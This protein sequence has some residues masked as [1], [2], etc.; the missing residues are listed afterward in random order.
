M[1][2]RVRERPRQSPATVLID[3][4]VLLD[5]LLD[6]APWAA[7]AARLLDA[8]TTGRLRGFVAVH[9]I[10][11]VHY[12]IEREHGRA[13]AATAISDLLDLLEVVPLDS[14]DLRRAL[15]LGLKDFE[16]AVHA[17]ACQKVGAQ[18]LVTRNERDYR[19]T[20]VTTR[21][22]AEVLAL[23]AITDR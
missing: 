19:D 15:A 16:D 3:T 20:G 14:A 5:L 2:R 9:A 21:T 8:I 13:T 11:T 7:D 10:T 6:R 22:G 1:P 12:L 23:L 17:A 18:F 4:N